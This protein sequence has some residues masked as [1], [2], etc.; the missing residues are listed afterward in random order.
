MNSRDRRLP[1]LLVIMADQMTPFFLGTYGHGAVRTPNLDELGRRG[2]RFDAAYTNCP[3]CVPA[4]ASFMTGRYASRS[5]CYDNGDSFPSLTPTLAHYLT[6]QGYDTILSGKMHFIGPDQ[7]HGFRKRLTTDIYP[8]GFDWSYDLPGDGDP[9]FDFPAQYQASNIGPGRTL[10]L[11]YD[12]ETHFRSLEYLRR[13]HDAPFL[14]VSSYTNPHPPFVAPKHFWDMYE[15][16]EIDLPHYPKNMDETYSAMD[17]AINRWHGVD[18]YDIRNP[19]HLATMRRGYAALISYIDQKVGE[20]LAA[21]EE[22]ELREDTVVIF[23]SD[24][25]EMLGEK[26]MIQKRCFHEWAVRVPMIIDL[27]N[28]ARQGRSMETPVSLVDLLPT[29]LDLAGVSDDS[30]VPIDGRSL[31]PLLTGEDRE[32]GD[33]ISEYH[34]EGVMRPCFMVRSGRYKY[35]F[36]REPRLFD[37][38]SDPGEWEN[39]AGLP[40]H[41]D[42]VTRLGTMIETQFDTDAIGRDVV[43]VLERKKIVRQAMHRN[44]THWD[45]QPYFDATEQYVRTDATKD[46]VRT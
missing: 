10:E 43:A 17:R 12:E 4:R 23:T 1:N 20:L 9:A 16:V 45:Y 11:Q 38:Q 14:L 29:L 44:D 15:G 36:D 7:L 27:P 40:E 3:I 2:V 5:G 34:G 8:A 22:R 35:V 42:L 13:S 26:G 39:L 33:V 46:Y 37:L 25:G 31:L 6:N 24:H 19:E 30:R 18:R 28:G 41:R 32:P 21:L